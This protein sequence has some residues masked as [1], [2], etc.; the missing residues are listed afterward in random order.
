MSIYDFDLNAKNYTIS[1][2]RGLLNLNVPYSHENIVNSAD[3]IKNKILQDE[4]LMKE[5]KEDL[6]K[7]ILK[8]ENILTNDLNEYFVKLNDLDKT[9]SKDFVTIPEIDIEPNNDDKFKSWPKGATVLYFNKNMEKFQMYVKTSFIGENVIWN[10][11][12]SQ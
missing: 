3:V 9:V 8:V 11:F 7:F 6:M 12:D 4:S 10:I 1:E 2:L 5:K